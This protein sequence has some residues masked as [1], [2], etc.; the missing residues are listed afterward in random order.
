[1]INMEEEY[2]I[3]EKAISKHI[4]EMAC[5][6]QGTH[7]LQ[8]L[9]FL[10]KTSMELIDNLYEVCKDTN[11]LSVIKKIIAWYKPKDKRKYIADRICEDLIKICQSNFGQYI[12]QQVL[13]SWNEEDVIPVFE[14]IK[15]NLSILILNKYSSW[16]LE[17]CKEKASPEVVDK[18]FKQSSDD[19]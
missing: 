2:Q 4:F 7:V 17:K 13:E 9:V 16:V 18:Y 15:K 8:K 19:S 14:E 1:M 11:G 5:D 10:E 12:I 3:L 6:P